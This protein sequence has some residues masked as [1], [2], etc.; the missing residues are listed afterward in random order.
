M[1]RPVKPKEL[2]EYVTT[3]S[4]LVRQVQIDSKLTEPQKTRVQKLASPLLTELRK[5]SA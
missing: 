2:A 3:V 5:L 4:R 1:P